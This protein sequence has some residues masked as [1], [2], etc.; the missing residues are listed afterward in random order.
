MICHDQPR[1]PM[2]KHMTEPHKRFHRHPKYKTADRVKNWHEYDQALR[3]R[4]DVTLWLS[5]AALD[6]W[7]VPKTGKRGAQPIYSDMAIETALTFRLLFACRCGKR[8]AS[9]PPS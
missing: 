5:P 8:Q 4:G 3:D 7:V 9:S 6:A 2:V 1:Q